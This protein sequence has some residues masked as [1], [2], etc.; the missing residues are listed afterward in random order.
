MQFD[1]AE[2]DAIKKRLTDEGKNVVWAPHPKQAEFLAASEFEVLYGGA[3]GAGKTDGILIDALGLQQKAIENRNYQAIIFRQTFP[4]LKDLIDRSL[5]LIPSI[6]KEAKY[7]KTMHVWTFPSGARLEFGHGQYEIDRFKYRGRAFQYLGF[8]ELTLWPTPVF[9][10]YL[11]TRVRSADP[12]LKCYVRANTNPDG[13]GA[14]WV[15]DRWKIPIEGTSTCFDVTLTDPETGKESV[16]TRR[17][18]SARLDDNPHLRDSGYRENLLLLGQNDP[19]SLKALLQGRWEPLPVRGAYYTP[20]IE[21]ARK[22]GRICKV[23][24]VRGHPVNTFWDIGQNDTTAIVC[25]QHVA[26][27]H[28]FLKGYESSGQPFEHFVQWLQSTGYVFGTHFLP[29][30]ANQVRQG[31]KDNRSSLEMLQELLPGHK[32]V[33]VPRVQDIRVGIE[34]T[35]RKL[36]EAVFEEVEC[37]ELVAALENYR[38]EWD[39]KMQTFKEKPLHDWASNYADAFRQWAQGYDMLNSVAPSSEPAPYRIKENRRRN[40]RV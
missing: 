20:E 37:G 22:E 28:L 9:Y 12:A 16:R 39:E 31:L 23:A 13:P 1:A 17:F 27:Q 34:L 24:Y 2:L 8:E 25:H 30:D 11:I 38:K 10:E 35:R 21:A 18:I 26:R 36:H 33:V 32:F 5:Q 3:A 29:H 40:W 4:D 7:D 6:N 15:K 14:K 19:D